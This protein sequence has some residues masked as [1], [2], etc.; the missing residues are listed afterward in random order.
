VRLPGYFSNPYAFMQ[1]CS[2]FVLP[3]PLEAC[4]TVVV[5]ALVLGRPVACTDCFGEP[6]GFV[7]QLP[8]VRVAPIEDVERL[9]R[10]IDECAHMHTAEPSTIDERLGRFSVASSAAAYVQLIESL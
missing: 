9:A 10:A 4:P 8:Q 1:L 5:E 3:S 2:A 6:L 7:K